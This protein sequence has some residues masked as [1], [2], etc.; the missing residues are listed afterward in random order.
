MYIM[1]FLLHYLFIMQKCRQ[2]IFTKS[3]ICT[4]MFARISFSCFKPQTLSTCYKFIKYLFKYHITEFC[5][6]SKIMRHHKYNN[7]PTK[8]EKSHKCHLQLLLFFQAQCIFP[9]SALAPAS[10]DICYI[11]CFCL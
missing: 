1:N 3:L 9:L 8:R 2:G 4:K 5:F 6:S 10:V 11:M 7:F